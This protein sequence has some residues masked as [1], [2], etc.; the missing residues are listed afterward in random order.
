M[1][2]HML[3]PSRSPRRNVRRSVLTAAAVALASAVTAIPSVA[4]A[5]TNPNCPPGS[6]FCA[7]T[8]AKP[9][10]PAGQPVA[11]PATGAAKGDKAEPL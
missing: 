7:D 2:T 10:A 6:W 3:A 5:Q 9:A 1:T 8:D 11:P 4:S